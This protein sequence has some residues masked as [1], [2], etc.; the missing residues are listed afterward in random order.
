MGRRKT[1]KR[2]IRETVPEAVK[3]VVSA[4]KRTSYSFKTAMSAWGVIN[5]HLPNPDRVLNKR[6]SNITLYRELLYDAHLTACLESRESVTLSYDWRIERNG[7]PARLFTAVEDWFFN[8]LERKT[9]VGDLSRDEFNSNV[10]DVIYWGYQ[11]AE[12]SWDMNMGHWVPITII[13]K[14]PEWF[15]WFINNDGVPELRF[16]SQS[17]MVSGEPPPDPWTL[18]CP[19]VKATYENPYG[20]GVAGRCFWPIVF[21]RAGLEFWLNF[22][23]RFGTPWIKG[24]ITGG[25]AGTTELDA[26]K[27]QLAALVQDAV[28][29]VSGTH[30]VEIL[31]SGKSRG[32][33][34][35]FQQLCDFMDSQ[36]S[37]T[38]LGHT[39]STDAGA[40]GSYGATKGAMTV[41][42]D[43]VARD[44]RMLTSIYND[45]INMICL[46]NG[47]YNVTRPTVTPYH[48]NAVDTERA[49][50]DEALTRAGVRFS[51][52]Y[53]TKA[54]NLDEDDIEEIIDT[55]K[56]QATATKP[57]KKDNVLDL[58]EEKKK[59]AKSE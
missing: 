20:R 19:R 11:P 38:I 40:Y 22:L 37:K 46:R 14:P 36:I 16:I 42:G 31:E 53:F 48:K 59:L 32:A 12:L 55:K 29:A 5:Q 9:T 23:E 54:Y 15:M 45:I 8:I 44:V 30:N 58:D 2:A 21:K 24:T 26:F 52:S 1:K 43:F 33:I 35:P 18:I 28:I 39:L 34:D 4:G 50:R 3:Q 47:Y 57:E 25:V 27:T 41:R 56:L 49:T 51:K 6:G 13:P 10:L 7:A 17:N